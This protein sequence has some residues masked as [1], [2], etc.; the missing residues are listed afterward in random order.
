MKTFFLAVAFFLFLDH[1][2]CAQNPFMASAPITV[3]N[4]PDK[5]GYRI[6]RISYSDLKGNPYLDN[7]W[8]VGS[9]EFANG[10]VFENLTLRFDQVN[11]LISCKIND[12]EKVITKPVRKFIV[13][14]STTG[15]KFENGY[16]KINANTVETFYEILTDGKISLLKLE[17]KSIAGFR[18]YN[19]I[20]EQKVVK[21]TEYYLVN[22]D[23]I[24][25]IKPN[26]SSVKKVLLANN[27]LPKDCQNI[28]R[29]DGELDLISFFRSNFN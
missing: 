24:N 28:G 9:I 12:T 10:E 23:K 27:I 3:F 5:Y 2:S 21:S 19:Q 4:A 8:V 29:I 20:V 18:G 16:P 7:G 11:E 1:I 6:P 25:V 14:D 17:S 13:G 22:G 15:K 26:G